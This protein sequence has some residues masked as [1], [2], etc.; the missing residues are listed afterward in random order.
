MMGFIFML[1]VDKLSDCDNDGSKH[2][3]RGANI[4]YPKPVRTILDEVSHRL[5]VLETNLHHLLLRHL[6]IADSLALGVGDDEVCFLGRYCGLD[7]DHLIDDF[8]EGSALF[9]VDKFFH[10]IT[11]YFWVV[12]C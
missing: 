2:T 8:A 4:R 9:E 3:D 11:F 5:T 6:E 1:F 7:P 10:Y 12:G